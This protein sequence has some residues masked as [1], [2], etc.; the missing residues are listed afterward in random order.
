MFA[1]LFF[2]ILIDFYFS[3]LLFVKVVYHYMPYLSRSFDKINK[4]FDM[5][6]FFNAQSRLLFAISFP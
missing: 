2:R 3:F 4:I 1:I 6:F 5:M